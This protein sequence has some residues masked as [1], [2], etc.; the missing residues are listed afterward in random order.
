MRIPH[1]CSEAGDVVTISLGVAATYATASSQPQA[2]VAAADKM[3]YQA[4]HRGRNQVSGIDCVL[5]AEAA[6]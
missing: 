5:S 3:L 1:A 2:L 6:S 4:K